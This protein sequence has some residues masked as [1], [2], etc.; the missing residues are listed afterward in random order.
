MLPTTTLINTALCL[1]YS[2]STIINMYR[3]LEVST[4]EEL[5]RLPCPEMTPFS[6]TVGTCQPKRAV[7]YLVT[8]FW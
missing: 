3:E 6:R 7:P 8:E 2:V 1:T 5:G 4:T